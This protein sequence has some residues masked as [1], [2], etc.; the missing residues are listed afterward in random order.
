MSGDY[1]LRPAKRDDAQDI[2]Q[3]I[4]SNKETLHRHLDWRTPNDWLGQQPYW[5]LVHGNKIL[6]A[7]AFPQDPQKMAWVRVFC[8]DPHLK[9]HETWR[10]LFQEGLRSYSDSER[11]TIASVAVS[12]WYAQTLEKN[13]FE[14]CQDI[15]VLERQFKTLPEK[16]SPLGVTI[17]RMQENDLITVAKVDQSAFSL[18]WSQSLEGLTAAFHQC[19][20]NTVVILDD[21]IVGYQMSSSNPFNAHLARLAVLPS[22]QHQGIGY[23]LVEDL[24]H[25]FQWQGI[26][27]L[28][29][30][31]QGDN[32][33]SL[34]LYQRIGFHRTGDKFPVFQYPEETER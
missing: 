10:L 30:N 3:L 12:S 27:Y 20:Y 11:P 19:S 8:V 5:L 18:M 2:N 24:I 6:A 31:T 21:Q 15:V 16:Y 23:K 22:L 1:N 32:D 33:S 25:Y 9:L 17:R 28:T 13:G 4:Q 14:H 26:A 34:S 7:L 29:V